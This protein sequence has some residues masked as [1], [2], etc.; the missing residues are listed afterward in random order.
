MYVNL[1]GRVSKKSQ[2]KYGLLPY[3]LGR[4][5]FRF[6]LCRCPW[7]DLDPHKAFVTM[8]CYILGGFPF[9]LHLFSYKWVAFESA[10]G[11]NRSVLGTLTDL[12]YFPT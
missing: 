11:A 12:L 5:I 2:E 1:T 10:L 9:K 6:P 3:P 8:G 4:N 7:S